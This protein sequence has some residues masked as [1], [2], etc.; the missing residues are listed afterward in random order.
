MGD[1]LTKAEI[2]AICGQIGWSSVRDYGEVLVY[3]QDDGPQGDSWEET[4]SATDLRE[5]AADL[6]RLAEHLELPRPVTP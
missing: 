2:E 3:V 1:R 5:L 6:L 4:A